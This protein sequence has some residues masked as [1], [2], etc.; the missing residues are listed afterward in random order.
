MRTGILF[1]DCSI[2]ERSILLDAVSPNLDV[3]CIHGTEDGLSQIAAAL[4]GRSHLNEIHIVCHGRPGELWFG[5]TPLTSSNLEEH[6]S[7]LHEIRTALADDCVLNLFACELASGGGGK[8][9]VD[10]LTQILD[11]EVHASSR[12]LGSNRGESNW[13]LEY[14]DRVGS[15]RGPFQREKVLAY[16]HALTPDVANIVSGPK[17]R[18]SEEAYGNNNLDVLRIVPL[19][20]R[21]I[22]VVGTHA[23]DGASIVPFDIGTGAVSI[24]I[25]VSATPANYQ[26]RPDAAALSD[27]LFAISWDSWESGRTDAP[28]AMVRLVRADGTFAS[29]EFRASETAVGA[30]AFNRIDALSSND[31]LVTWDHNGVI[32]GRAFDDTGTPL[33]AQFDISGQGA[34]FRREVATNASGTF[35]VTWSDQQ[36]GSTAQDIYVRTGTRSGPEGTFH[37]I[38][39]TSGPDILPQVSAID[40][41]TFMV[42][43]EGT[44][45][46]RNG[47][48]VFGRR[49]DLS[50]A[51]LGPELLINRQHRQGDQH[52]S[53]VVQIS[54]SQVLVTWIDDNDNQVFGKIYGADGRSSTD[55]FPISSNPLGSK[56]SQ[57]ATSLGDGTF[58][59]TWELAGDGSLHAGIYAQIVT[60]EG[61]FVGGEI[62][63]H[64]SERAGA[65]SPFW[66]QVV[67]TVPGTFTTVWNEYGTGGTHAKTIGTGVGYHGNEDQLLPLSGVSVSA[68]GTQIVSVE[69]TVQSGVLD[70]DLAGDAT[71]SGGR[72]GSG[73]LVVSGGVADVNASLG[74]LNYKGGAD[75]YGVDSLSIRSDALGTTDRDTVAITLA[76]VDDPPHVSVLAPGPGFQVNATTAGHQYGNEA[77][78]FSDGTFAVVWTSE[79]QDGSGSGVYGMIRDALGDPHSV[80]FRVN[81]TTAENQ[82][83]PQIASVGTD[84]FVV[85]WESEGQDGSGSGVYARLFN[86]LGQPLSEEIRV[87]NFVPGDQGQSQVHALLSGDFL[88]SWV[89]AGQDGS[90]GG[91]YAQRFGENAQKIGDE[92]RIN[93]VTVGDQG[94]HLIEVADD[95]SFIAL[96]MSDATAENDAFVVRRFYADGTPASGEARIELH[97]GNVGNVTLSSLTSLSDG[98]FLLVWEEGV[99]R[100]EADAEIGTYARH[101][102]GSGEP[103]GAMMEVLS[104]SYAST[105]WRTHSVVPSTDG[106]ALVFVNFPY[107]VDVP[108]SLV[109]V[110]ESR[111]DAISEAVVFNEDFRNVSGTLLSTDAILISD[112]V[113]NADG[114]FLYG[115]LLGTQGEKLSDPFWVSHSSE[116]KP[117]VRIM[118]GFDEGVVLLWNTLGQDSDG[119][120]VN[121]RVY[122]R[123]VVGNYEAVE[124]EVLAIV[125]VTV[126]DDSEVV[127]AGVSVAHGT[128]QVVAYGEAEVTRLQGLEGVSLFITGSVKDVNATL[129]TL[130]YQ[131]N[132][133]FDDF[134]ILYVSA[135]SGIVG[136]MP[137]AGA[138]IHFV[139]VDD[140]LLPGAPLSDQYAAVG[141]EFQ[142]QVDRGAVIDVDGDAIV[143]AK[144][145]NGD[146]LPDW[147]TFNASQWQFSG[148]PGDGDAGFVDVALTFSDAT[149]HWTDI[150]RILVVVG[151]EVAGTDDGDVIVGTE[152]TDRIFGKGG[153]DR[154][155][156]LGGNDIIDGG[157]DQDE[158]F[159]GLGRDV[160]SG[161]SG[162]DVFAGAWTELDQDR[163]VDFSVGDA[164]RI[165]G[166]TIGPWG[167]DPSGAF[168]L[169]LLSRDFQQIQLQLPAGLDASL[170]HVESGVTS[171]GVSWSALVLGEDRDHDGID[172]R[173]DNALGVD[174]PDQRD[175]DG[176]GFGNIVDADLSQDLIVDLVDLSLFEDAFG[177]EDMNADF[178]GDGGVDL[179]DLS[180]LDS[181]FGAAPGP[182]AFHVPLL[183][184][185]GDGQRWEL[186]VA[187]TLALDVD[188][189][190]SAALL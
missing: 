78:S 67:S 187:E 12:I 176:D 163:I 145:V 71:L 66:H 58:V 141:A 112:V 166:E 40:D 14:G 154:L 47:L 28:D 184:P 104:P 74:T 99:V 42:V 97:G 30:Q 80:E 178:N 183:A 35:A 65:S 127:T 90:G 63:M 181:M 139:P 101:I 41:S 49:V 5:R 11:V 137:E 179:F 165:D 69:L 152:V 88:V 20:A 56:A 77:I 10:E 93:A 134:D 180:L 3:V 87:N 125:G 37:Q 53:Q 113:T 16:R 111:L 175:S 115:Q 76:A 159:G 151:V 23:P 72:A 24:D 118:P 59:V 86:A 26:I 140:A 27:D 2:Q 110:Y 54:E 79:G 160:L 162:S 39:D 167:Y 190:T 122:G 189:A 100:G 85:V 22:V 52:D 62:P 128:L 171:D 148:M 164:I 114:S 32:E 7:T 109:S 60:N 168:Y 98:S 174:N 46:G 133:N 102:G 173:T 129:S 170:F 132:A 73:R 6:R 126:G 18:V 15:N 70:I 116:I 84:R 146:P 45:P 48:D 34:F 89:S 169:E 91:I 157:P 51:P 96:W 43:W 106:K 95:G 177:T 17:L 135:G 136:T 81:V 25:P 158:I 149:S 155:V 83:N 92:F 19:N 8:A 117:N 50:G 185:L 94:R 1:I 123:G 142:W 156:G 144:Q 182:S 103:L 188:H 44:S 57:R 36:Q 120:D 82:L 150:V 108:G 29:S 55:E 9:F 121:G 153:D 172:D 4:R 38:N 131:G 105:S 138:P 64:A 161:G 119:L 130:T 186:F 147:L 124:D 61:R 13:Q 33:G 21:K 143:A 68:P 75:F 107:D 31:F